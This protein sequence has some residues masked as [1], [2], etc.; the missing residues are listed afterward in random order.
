M[1]RKNQDS[2]RL[3]QLVLL[4]VV[5]AIQPAC[6]PASEPDS[7]VSEL[8]ALLPAATRGVL[9]VDVQ[10]LRAGD[11]AE[12]FLALLDGQ[13][14]DPALA[15]PLAELGRQLLPLQ[16]ATRAT[17]VVLAHATVVRDGPLL[18]ARVSPGELAALM[19][20]DGLTAEEPY[21]GYAVYSHVESGTHLTVLPS[22]T[23]V[24]GQAAR[25]RAAIDVYDATAPAAREAAAIG[26]YLAELSD[27]SPINFV[28]GLPALYREVNAGATLEAARAVRVALSLSAG[29][30][31]GTASVYVPG[32][33]DFVD[34]YN[35]G[36]RSRDVAPLRV[37]EG[38]ELGVDRI[39]LDIPAFSPDR[40]LPEVV[41][42][43]HV[44]KLLFHVMTMRDQALRIATGET[45]PW[46]N[47][48]VDSTP[49]SI[50]I[51]FEIPESRV[52][53]FSARVL[54][55]GFE[56]Q[57]IRILET[58]RP[59]YA[60]S[61]NIYEALGIAPGVRFEWSVFVKTPNQDA[62]HFL[63][64]QALAAE[65]SLDPVD[66]FTAPQP[67]S[68]VLD[69]DNGSLVSEAM[70]PRGDDQMLPYFSSSIAWPQAAPQLG[71][72]TR[73]FAAANDFIYWR[74]GI[75]D[76]A[77]Y[78]G[79]MHNRNVIVIPP[80]DYEIV[81][82]TPWA[83]FASPVPTSVYVYSGALDILVSPWWNL[84][85]D[86][87]D[88]TPDHL[89]NL[90]K[91]KRSIY[92]KMIAADVAGAFEGRNEPVLPFV[93]PNTVPSLLVNFTIPED[94]AP[95]FEAALGLP[96]GVT[97]ERTRILEDDPAEQ[98]L[99]SLRVFEIEDAV[100]GTRAEW[101]VYVDD[102]AGREH[103]MVIETMSADAGLDPV[104]VLRRPSVVEHRLVGT[105][106]AT[107][108]S[109]S[110]IEFA[111]SVDVADGRPALQSLDW[112]EA[113]D[114]VCA[115]NGVCDKNYSDGGTIAAPLTLIDPNAVQVTLQSP[116]SD[117]IETT[118]SSVMI[119]TNS[120]QLVRKP[121]LTIQPAR[122][123]APFAP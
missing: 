27:D 80:R 32:A 35:T 10:R 39:D 63:V 69:V 71:K 108:L 26:P 12:Q 105:K 29:K 58:D 64:I 60:L 68:H 102:G 90:K 8:V 70:Q 18:V 59:H 82:D 118:P 25:V 101:T 84:D 23:V 4:A 74:G 24:V 88:V 123:L 17:T 40:T 47:F 62:P 42:S 86:V 104:R 114:R 95:A 107:V 54:P 113:Y 56:M 15:E 66:L 16:L 93:V 73:E 92:P 14:A 109:S 112:V 78:S 97:L 72:T 110:S 65:P 79:S 38:R 52:A 116:W 11:S 20:P 9:A 49:P 89:A 3:R 103:M 122:P 37:E 99:L 41:A 121:W 36:T 34:G 75:A 77:L 120:Q 57:K 117:F 19:S 7:D 2:P 28:Y 119:R 5:L 48:F 21:H 55:S 98:Y 87:L 91:I 44:V 53:A 111:A 106:L 43:R 46:K 61:L 51:N 100:E 1:T 67:I 45:K 6:S 96:G 83:E 30:L 22:E 94:K 81:D 50:F 85:A 31:S 76:R 33:A 115:I 13:G